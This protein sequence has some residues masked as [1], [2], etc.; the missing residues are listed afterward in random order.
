MINNIINR[1][2][3]ERRKIKWQ[4]SDKGIKWFFPEI[5][6][7]KE[8]WN[9][10]GTP[11]LTQEKV[12]VSHS[13]ISIDSFRRYCWS[14][15]PIIWLDQRH[16]WPHLA[17][18]DNLWCYLLLTIISIQKIKDI[19]CFYQWCCWSKNYKTWLGERHTWPHWTKELVSDVDFPWR[20][21]T[22]MKTK[23]SFDSFLRY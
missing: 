5:L 1:L 14:Q 10:I 6:M 20:L 3:S 22:C 13:K 12:N 17:K 4:L 21:I 16:T 18:S 15:N 2:I 19:D 9:L 11:D 7:L 8:S 23:T